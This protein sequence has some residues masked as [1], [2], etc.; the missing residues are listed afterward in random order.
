ML[1]NIYTSFSGYAQ[2]IRLYHENKEKI[3]ETIPISFENWFSANMSAVLGGILDKLESELNTI[4]IE[5]LPVSIKTIIQKNDFLSHYG[6]QKVSDCNNTTIKYL[7]IKPTDGRFFHGYITNELLN[8]PELPTMTTALKKKISE[9][10]YEIFVNAQ[11]HSETE[12]IYTCGQFFPTKHTIEFTIVD[13]GLGFKKRINTRFGVNMNSTQAIQ[14]ATSDGHS[15][16]NGISGGIGLALLKEFVL[17]NKGKLQIVSDDGFYQ[18]DAGGETTN[19]FSEPFPG[20]IVNLQFRTDDS[21]SY[22][23]KSETSLDDIF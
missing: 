1:N 8:R 21:N 9:S 10:I 2:M 19:S 14:W 18:F 5:N 17:I 23:L 13:T 4:K 12:F 6:Y 16:K 20:S 7:K 22:A 3:F 15:T 11:I